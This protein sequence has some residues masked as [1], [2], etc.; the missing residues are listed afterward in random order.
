MLL[1]LLTSK[2]T[3]LNMESKRNNSVIAPLPYVICFEKDHHTSGR[4]I[5]TIWHFLFIHTCGLWM[6]EWETLICT[7]SVII[8]LYEVL[9]V[10]PPKM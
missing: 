8:F 7:F 3:F 10:F 1:C 2:P 9:L 5:T 4:Y 6:Y